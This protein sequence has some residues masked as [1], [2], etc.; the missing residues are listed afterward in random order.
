MA[1]RTNAIPA[2]WSKQMML[3]LYATPARSTMQ[4]DSFHSGISICRHGGD[5]GCGD[6][7]DGA[8]RVLC[9]QN[10]L[11]DRAA[12]TRLAQGDH[13]VRVA[14]PAFVERHQLMT[15]RG[16]QKRASQAQCADMRQLEQQDIV[17]VAALSVLWHWW[18]HGSVACSVVPWNFSLALDSR[19][20]RRRPM[21]AMGH[22]NFHLSLPVLHVMMRFMA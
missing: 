16:L 6:S 10:L 18:K 4:N 7:D 15:L 12:Q 19:Q 22:W 8:E 17:A 20:I 9:V 3:R 2:P 5:N 13:S 11:C 21:A 1:D 14:L